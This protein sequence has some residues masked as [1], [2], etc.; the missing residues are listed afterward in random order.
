MA[1][2]EKRI[3]SL[4]LILD[5]LSYHSLYA[6][7]PPELLLLDEPSNHLDLASLEALQL[8]LKRYRGALLLVSHDEIFLQSIGIDKRLQMDPEGWRLELC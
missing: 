4:Y 6:Q 5:K 2:L 3:V 8:M 7:N 1:L